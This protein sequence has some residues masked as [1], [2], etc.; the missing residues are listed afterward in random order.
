MSM[1]R[2][3]GTSEMLFVN[4]A[5]LC[6]RRC[7]LT[8]RTGGGRHFRQPEVQNLG[9]FAVGDENV[10]GLDIAVNNAF[11]VS[12]VQPIGNLNC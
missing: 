1:V 3:T 8:G 4:R 9:V 12:G 6:V 7:N 11:G 5:R 10:R 2:R